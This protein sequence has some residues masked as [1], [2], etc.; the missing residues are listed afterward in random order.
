[1]GAKSSKRPKSEP[2][3][4]RYVEAEVKASPGYHPKGKEE[5][6]ADYRTFI[7]L[8]SMEIR[9]DVRSPYVNDDPFNS[10]L[11]YVI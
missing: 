9:L 6:P 3:A 1:M 11:G 5:R 4:V 2:F 8:Q 10:A 7:P